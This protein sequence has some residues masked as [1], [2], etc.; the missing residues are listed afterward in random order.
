MTL[1]SELPSWKVFFF[2]FL[3]AMLGTSQSLVFVPI[4]NTLPGEPMLSTWWIKI[5]TYL[6]PGRFLSVL[7]HNFLPKIVIHIKGS[8]LCSS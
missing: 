6:Q 5:S 4:M 8:V 1:Y 2:V 3:L 7:L